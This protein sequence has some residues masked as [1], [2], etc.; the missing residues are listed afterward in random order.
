V[1]ESSYTLIPRGDATE[2]RMQMRYRV[3]TQFN[4]YAEPLARRLLG[5]FQEVILEFYRRRSESAS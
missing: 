2:L 1:M 5:N 3:S 4:W